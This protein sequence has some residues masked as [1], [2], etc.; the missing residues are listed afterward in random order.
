V[1]DL[2]ENKNF[3]RW[4]VDYQMPVLDDAKKDLWDPEIP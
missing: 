2:G 3:Q 4:A 1:K